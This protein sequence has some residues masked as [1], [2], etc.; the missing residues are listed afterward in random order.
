MEIEGGAVFDPSGLM[1]GRVSVRHDSEIMNKN[2]FRSFR[3]E[4]VTD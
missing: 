4:G 2:P 1:E 3:T